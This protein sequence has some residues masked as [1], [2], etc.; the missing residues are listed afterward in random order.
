MPPSQSRLP[1]LPVSFVVVQSSAHTLLPYQPLA[2]LSSEVEFL[3][4]SELGH[5][6]IGGLVGL[7]G[8]RMRERDGIAAS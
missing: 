4:G 6:H 3:H 2:L 8:T 5:F 7:A 1:A